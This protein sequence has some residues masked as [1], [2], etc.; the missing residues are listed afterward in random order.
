MG[1]DLFPIAPLFG[2][3]WMNVLA[4]QYRVCFFI[5]VLCPTSHLESVTMLQSSISNIRSRKVEPFGTD[6]QLQLIVFF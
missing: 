5:Y 3:Y 6:I 4:L 1:W 2:Q